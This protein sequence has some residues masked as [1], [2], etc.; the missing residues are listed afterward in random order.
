M[1]GSLSDKLATLAGWLMLAVLLGAPIGV[2]ALWPMETLVAAGIAA[3]ICWI[4]L[5][6]LLFLLIV[7]LAGGG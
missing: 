1:P 5:H 6:P 4:V 3:V 7:L 2:L